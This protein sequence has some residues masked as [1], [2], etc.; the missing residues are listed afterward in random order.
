MQ[1]YV[2]LYNGIEPKGPGLSK[3]E[4]GDKGEYVKCVDPCRYTVC[5]TIIFKIRVD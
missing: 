3:A 2:A 5:G 4:D 1:Y